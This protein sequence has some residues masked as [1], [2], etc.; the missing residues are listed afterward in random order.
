MI[1]HGNQRGGSKN[2]ALQLPKAENE[3]VDVHE[4]QGFSAHPLETLL[5]VNFPI[6][7]K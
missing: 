6:S 4:L 1:L 7:A 5:R 3:H 2:L